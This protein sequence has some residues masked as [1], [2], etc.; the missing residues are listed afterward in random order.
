MLAAFDR[1]MSRCTRSAVQAS[2]GLYQVKL[3]Q[4][5]QVAQIGK[6]WKSCFLLALLGST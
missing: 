1:L 5:F 6:A 4:L 3:M 2:R